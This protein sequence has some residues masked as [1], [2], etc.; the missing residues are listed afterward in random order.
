MTSAVSCLHCPS[1]VAPGSRLCAGCG[2]PADAGDG[3]VLRDDATRLASTPFT[4]PRR[5]SSPSGAT[6]PQTGWLSSSAGRGVGAG[7]YWN[8]TVTVRIT[9]TGAPLSSVG[10]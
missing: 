1:P 5:P 4:P 3:T 8:A 7:F 10:S 9:G 2:R 6:T